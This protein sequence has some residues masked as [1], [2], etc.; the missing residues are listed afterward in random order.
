MASFQ[1]LP[2]NMSSTSSIIQWVVVKET[3]TLSFWSNELSLYLAVVSIRNSD[4]TGVCGAMLHYPAI[5]YFIK[6]L[7]R[8][9]ELKYIFWSKM[10]LFS[11]LPIW[12]KIF[13]DLKSG[14]KLGKFFVIVAL[15]NF[16]VCRYLLA[17]N[18]GIKPKSILIWALCL[19]SSH[20]IIMQY[21]LLQGPL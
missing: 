6:T 4:N 10:P 21:P 20:A 1:N 14:Y 12:L 11:F 2:E 9:S 8:K 3:A 16:Y 17:S 5:S 15:Y 13:S 19:W 7:P 18:I